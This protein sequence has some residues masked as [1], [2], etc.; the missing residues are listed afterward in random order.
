MNNSIT[1]GGLTADKIKETYKFM[2]DSFSDMR[3]NYIKEWGEPPAFCYMR[4][5]SKLTLM[6]VTPYQYLFDGAQHPS[7]AKLM[8]VIV[9]D[10]HKPPM[11]Y[12]WVSFYSE[13]EL[14]RAERYFIENQTV[15]WFE[16]ELA[17]PRFNPLKIISLLATDKPGDIL[18]REIVKVKIH[19]VVAREYSRYKQ[20]NKK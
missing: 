19:K 6:K 13:Y 7:N 16:I 15:E 9:L 2:M 3:E 10:G 17:K 18:E 14:E 12:G 1:V 8:D 11:D 20:M 4:D 5:T